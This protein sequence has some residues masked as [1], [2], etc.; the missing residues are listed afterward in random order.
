MK[1]SSLSSRVQTSLESWSRNSIKL[2]RTGSRKRFLGFYDDSQTKKMINFRSR[3]ESL[4]SE[5]EPQ[6]FGITGMLKIHVQ[7]QW[8]N[9]SFISYFLLCPKCLKLL[10]GYHH[11]HFLPFVS[12]SLNA[13]RLRFIIKNFSYEYE[14]EKSG[15]DLLMLQK[16]NVLKI[17]HIENLRNNVTVPQ[18][19]M[20][21]N[22]RFNTDIYSWCIFSPRILTPKTF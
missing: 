17:C 20:K 11:Q 16:V 22:P 13:T 4:L 7:R 10:N 21:K 9:H 12:N 8:V 18:C 1:I 6:R 15:V 19:Q 14:N 5:I 2:I 3:K